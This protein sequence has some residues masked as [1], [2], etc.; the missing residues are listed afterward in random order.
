MVLEGYTCSS[1]RFSDSRIILLTAPS[2]PEVYFIGT[3]TCMRFSSPITA[4]GP[5]P[6]PTEFPVELNNEHLNLVCVY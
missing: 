3:V 6:I 1:A 5:S 2:H 4:A